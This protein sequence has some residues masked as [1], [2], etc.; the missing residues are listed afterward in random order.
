MYTIDCQN[1]K[2]TTTAS[3]ATDIKIKKL[4]KS[5]VEIT[6]SINVADFL[7]FRKQAIQNINDE[8]NIDGFRKG[9]VP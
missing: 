7:T 8:V 1:M 2:K 3:I 5:K 6:G 9:K 4:E